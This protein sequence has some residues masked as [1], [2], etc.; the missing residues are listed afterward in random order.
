M[1]NRL[2]RDRSG[3]R[4]VLVV[5]DEPSVHRLLRDVFAGKSYRIEGA[6]NADDAIAFLRQGQVDAIILDVNLPGRSGLHVLEYVRTN[7]QLGNTP[8]LILT[9]DAFTAEGEALV[10]RYRP[11]VFYKH[12]ELEELATYVE[13][14][15]ST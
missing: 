9:G 4:T 1:A 5:D 6:L 3:T 15:T 10:A 11:Y 12:E 14:L 13:K 2:A 8:V 7:P